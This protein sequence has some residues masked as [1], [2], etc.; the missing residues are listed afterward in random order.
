MPGD[1]PST[2]SPSESVDEPDCCS[3]GTSP[4]IRPAVPRGIRPGVRLGI[5]VGAVRVGVAGSDPGAR[6]AAPVETLRRADSP[7][8]DLDQ[9][10]ALVEERAVVEVVVG[11]PVSLSGAE[12]AAAQTVRAY[13]GRLAARIAPVPVRLVDERLS[14]VSVQRGLREAGVRGRKG[15][16]VIDQAAAALVLQTALDA[17]RTNGVRLGET[18]EVPGVRRGVPSQGGQGS[19]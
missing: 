5:D 14:T 8:G 12:G 18:I 6:M 2:P 10:A 15:R 13:A 19:P 11:L 17:E 9:I 7:G 16:S 4:G 1:E 3:S